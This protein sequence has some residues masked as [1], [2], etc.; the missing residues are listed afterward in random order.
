[1]KRGESVKETKGTGMI[2]TFTYTPAGSLIAWLI[3][4]MD[5]K[6]LPN[7]NNRIYKI[8]TDGFKLRDDSI[9]ITIFKFLERCKKYRDVW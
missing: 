1:M 4:S 3:K 7:A 2:D 6:H 9:S 8:L 5:P